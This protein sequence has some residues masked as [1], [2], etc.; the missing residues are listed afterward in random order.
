MSYYRPIHKGRQ[1]AWGLAMR[2]EVQCCLAMGL[3]RRV[4]WRVRRRDGIVVPAEPLDN[5]ACRGDFW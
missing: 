3:V 1:K 2:T 5:P 4:G